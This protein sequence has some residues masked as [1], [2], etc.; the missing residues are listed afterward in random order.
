[1]VGHEMGVRKKKN[2]IRDV[3][4]LAGV[5]YQTVS[6]VMNESESVAEETRKRVLQAMRELDFVPSKVA[7]MLNTHQ[8]HT[9]ELIVV[10]IRQGGASRNRSKAWPWPRAMLATICWSQ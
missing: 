2:T 9:L 6:R 5:S 7:Q 4:K 8:S 10:N 3:A 1:M